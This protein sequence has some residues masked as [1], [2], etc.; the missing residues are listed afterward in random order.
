[1]TNNLF[2]DALIRNI[3]GRKFMMGFL[4]RSA[5]FLMARGRIWIASMISSPNIPLA[6]K[7]LR[8]VEW[9]KN[10]PAAR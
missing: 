2:S 7:L 4:K 10:S 6:S 9:N 8:G 1:M 3:N 5:L